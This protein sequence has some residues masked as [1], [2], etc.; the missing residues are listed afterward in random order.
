MI[1]DT[2]FYS[3]IQNWNLEGLN[4]ASLSRCKTQGLIIAEVY[5]STN[6]LQGYSIHYSIDEVKKELKR[7]WDSY[8]F[9]Y[10]ESDWELEKLPN[11]FTNCYTDFLVMSPEEFNSKGWRME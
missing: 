8:W 11:G 5:R 7:L 10:I 9:D 1:T 2:S 3:T 6:E 4:P